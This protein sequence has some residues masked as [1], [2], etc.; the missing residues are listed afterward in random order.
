[1]G[2]A[3]AAFSQ[4]YP[5]YESI[6]GVYLISMYYINFYYISVSS[7]AIAVLFLKSFF[8]PINTDFEV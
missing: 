1:M 6:N 3:D 8:L 7:S 5:I 2:S 4:I